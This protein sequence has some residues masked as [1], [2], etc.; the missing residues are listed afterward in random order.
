MNRISR[1]AELLY[2]RRPPVKFHER[3]V[4][5]RQIE[6]RVRAA[7]PTESRVSRRRGVDRQQ[8]HDPTTERVNDVRQFRDEIAQFAR[9]RNDRIALLVARL[10]LC[11]QLFVR[12][13]DRAFSLT[14]QPGER[15]VNRVG[16]AIPIGMNRESDIQAVRPNLPA[17]VVDRIRLRLEIADLRQR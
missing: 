7:V 10:E 4:N 14:K 15:A 8:M 16:R 2:S 9:R 5:R 6:A 1:F 13:A 11:L 12:G 17:R 3:R